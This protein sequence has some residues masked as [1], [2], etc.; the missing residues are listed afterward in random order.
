[1]QSFVPFHRK[2]SPFPEGDG[3]GGDGQDPLASSF[4]VDSPDETGEVSR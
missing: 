4:G 1:M 3:K 2:R